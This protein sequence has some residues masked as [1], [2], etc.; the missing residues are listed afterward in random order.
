MFVGPKTHGV[1]VRPVRGVSGQIGEGLAV[2]R[3][4]LVTVAQAEVN[5]AT[6]AAGSHESA[7]ARLLV[8]TTQGGGEQRT[9]ESLRRQRL[10][11][12]MGYPG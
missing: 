6:A 4:S 10:A 1:P 2:R 8:Y 12:A 9:D 7:A 3:Q 5:R 11:E